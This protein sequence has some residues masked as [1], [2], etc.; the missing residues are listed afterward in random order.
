MLPRA[1]AECGQRPHL[2]GDDDDLNLRAGGGDELPP[3]EQGVVAVAH[4]APDGGLL[5]GPGVGRWRGGYGRHRAGSG[6][7]VDG[8]VGF[9]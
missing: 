7:R 6:V 4:D 3:E 5:A 8:V 2:P 9:E 1:M